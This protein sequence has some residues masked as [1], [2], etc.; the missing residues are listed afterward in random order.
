[1]K[2]MQP[3]PVPHHARAAGQ[4]AFLSKERADGRTRSCNVCFTFNRSDMEPF[5]GG[6]GFMACGQSPGY[7]IILLYLNSFP[8]WLQ[9]MFGAMNGPIRAYV[10]LRTTRPWCKS[11]ITRPRKIPTS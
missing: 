6:I 4:P 10:S 9:Y 1:M 5:L 3:L 7:N 11:S 2:A 8:S